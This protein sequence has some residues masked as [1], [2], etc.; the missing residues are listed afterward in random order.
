MTETISIRKAEEQDCRSIFELS[1]ELA[2]HHEMEHYCTI[3]YENFKENGFGENPAWWSYIVEYNGRIVGF[4]LYYVRFA[5]WR[6]RTLYLEDFFIQ[7]EMRGKGLGKLLFDA[8]I[9]EAKNQKMVAINWQVMRWN[10]AAIKFYK[11]YK[12]HF[13]EERVYCSL[14]I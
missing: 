7:G 8:L 11:N 4:A 9:V 12:T 2:R 5:T 10:E 1:H 14:E 13:D 3:E 6:G